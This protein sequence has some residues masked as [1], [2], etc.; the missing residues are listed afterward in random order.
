MVDIID[1]ARAFLS[2]ER[3]QGDAAEAVREFAEALTDSGVFLPT[4]PGAVWTPDRA[5]DVIEL[6]DA[7]NLVVWRAPAS[8][9]AATFPVPAGRWLARMR[10][11]RPTA[12]S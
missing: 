9:G 7:D 1:A 11:Y 8:G 12:D 4:P 10:H 2:A 6:F 5:M 3:Y